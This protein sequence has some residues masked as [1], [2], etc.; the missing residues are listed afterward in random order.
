M[1]ISKDK[2]IFDY[3]YHYEAT[4][5]QD[6]FFNQPINGVNH[7]FTWSETLGQIRRL[8]AYLKGLNLEPS[9]NIAIISKNCAEWIMTDVAIQM[10]GHV[11]VPL[12]PTLTGSQLNDILVHAEAKV[13]FIGKLDDWGS[14]KN[15]ITHQTQYI[16]F[17]TYNPDSSHVQW[18]DIQKNT[19]A[20]TE[21]YKPKGTDIYTIIYTSGTTGNP[22]GV[23]LNYNNLAEVLHAT[24]DITLINSDGNKFFSYLPLSHIAERILVETV[25]IVSGGTI[26]FAENL[27]TFAKNLSEAQPTHFLAVPRIW[28]KFQ[29]G[30]LTKLPQKKLD[31]LLKIPIVNS[32]IRSKIK[33]GLGLQ[34]SKLTVTGAAPMPLSLIL[35]FRKLGI[36]IQE[37]YGMTE[38]MGATCSMPIQKIKD[39]Y[40]G[41]I[42]DGLDAKI[43][44]S[45]GEILTRSA[46]NMVGYFKEPKMSADTID[47]EGW[48]HTGDVGELDA[49][50]Y[51]KITGRVKEMYKTSKGEYV[52]PAQIEMTMAENQ[53]IEQVCVTGESLP[54]PMALVVVSAAF[55]H[56]NQ[57]EI[58]K[59]FTEQLATLNPILKPYERLQKIVILKEPL[60]LENNMLTPTLKLKRNIIDKNFSANYE[61]WYQSPEKIIFQ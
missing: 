31:L 55:S 45:T 30:I 8:A 3:L 47:A 6:V 29:A 20:M 48:L 59:N 17:P 4:K 32:L 51:L 2:N 40:V 37:A 61:K 35:W 11:S 13:T 14:Q 16:S 60:T 1:K 5:P 41:K 39:G 54:Q 9:S 22:K 33:K 25:G 53:L 42:Y 15:E 46:W 38:N 28:S 49:E 24:Q 7:T 10:A 23:M 56:L 19:P 27:D 52:A 18:A 43:D 58:R 12:Y 36:T 26:F 34:N 44:P 50:N 21:N 57:D